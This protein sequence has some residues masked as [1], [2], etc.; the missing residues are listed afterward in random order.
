MS[1]YPD[2]NY[3]SLEFYTSI[4]GQSCE[5]PKPFSYWKGGVFCGDLT[6]KSNLDV[7]QELTALTATIAGS[8]F[9]SSAVTIEAPLTVNAN[10]TIKAQ[11]TTDGL[12][13]ANLE[14]KPVQLP[15]FNNYYVL[16]SYIP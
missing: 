3:G 1:E 5:Y 16:A 12:V 8:K 10:T 2:S 15:P 6:V 13:V 7:E 11:L 4:V 14:F 9:T